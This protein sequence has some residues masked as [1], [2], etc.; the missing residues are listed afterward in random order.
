M[1][2]PLQ[3]KFFNLNQLYSSNAPFINTHSFCDV[4]FNDFKVWKGDK[5]LSKNLQNI[6]IKIFTDICQKLNDFAALNIKIG[7]YVWVAF[8][9]NKPSFNKWDIDNVIHAIFDLLVEKCK[10]GHT[11]TFD[12]GM[13][14]TLTSSLFASWD[15]NFHFYISFGWTLNQDEENQKIQN[16]SRKILD[17]L[18]QNKIQNWPFFIPNKFF[19]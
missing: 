18:K 3:E 11:K 5:V 15:E 4:F 19:Q 7:I 16:R 17:Y 9:Y 1:L 12:D 14:E 6:D 13:I 10:N 2:K 8:P